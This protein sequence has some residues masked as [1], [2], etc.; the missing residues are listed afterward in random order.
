MAPTAVRLV[1]VEGENGDGALVDED[2][3][4]VSGDGDAATIGAAEQVISAIL[5][6]REG[7]SE[8]GYQ[9]TSTGVTWRDPAQAAALRDV[10]ARREIENVAGLGVPGRRRAGSRG[11][12]RN[13]LCADRVAVHR[14]RGRHAGG[15]R[16]CGRLGYRH[17]STL[18]VRRR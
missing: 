7:A 10:L 13:Q 15:C 1:L 5:G 16:Q 17:S 4:D 18:T 6:T 8:G 2:A 3:F 9:L 11:G 14:T 12:Q